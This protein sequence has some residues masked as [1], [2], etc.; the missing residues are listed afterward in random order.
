MKGCRPLA[1]QEVMRVMESFTGEFAMRDRALFILGTKTGFRISELL[2]LRVGDVLQGGQM[3]DRVSV[4]RRNMK[5]RIEGRTVVLHPE[6]KEALG[7]WLDEMGESSTDTPLFRSRKG[8]DRPVSRVHAWRV[9]NKAFD[10]GG[11]TGK[12]GTHS[13]RKTFA[14]K[15]YDALGHDLVKLQRA[16]GHRNVNSTASYLSFRQ[17]EID[18]AILSA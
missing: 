9:L 5:K 2:S 4:A 8:D 16:L 15:V 14:S 18:R 7:S 3:L 6:A 12:T 1:E 13:M 10:A 17:E 11:V